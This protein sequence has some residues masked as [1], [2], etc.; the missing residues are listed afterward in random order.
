MVGIVSA[1]LGGLVMFAVVQSR[2]LGKEPNP[3]AQLNIENTPVNREAHGTTSYAPVLKR[4]APSVVNIYSTRTVRLRRMPLMNPFFNDPMFRQFFGPGEGDS[5]GGGRGG[6]GRGGQTFTRKEQSLGS[7]VI[8]SADGY[9]LTANHV[10]EGADP[11]GVKV[12]LPAGGKEYTA[13]IIGTDPPTDVAVLKIDAS[14]LSATW[15]WR[16][17][18]RLA[19]GRR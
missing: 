11:D 6:N 10:V 4:A 12:A 17:A 13:K 2:L 16:S 9:I 19:S 8:V 3:P 7:G 14:D 18:I 15:Y 1:V 5:Q